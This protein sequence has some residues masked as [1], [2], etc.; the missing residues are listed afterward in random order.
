MTRPV[1]GPERTPDEAERPLLRVVKG[2]PTPEELAALVAAL[3]ATSAARGT[4]TGG[5]PAAQPPSAWADPAGAVRSPLT[6]GPG[7]WARSGREPGVRTRAG[8]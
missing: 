5:P 7:A 8:W 4:A 6:V 2:D 3:V 1:T